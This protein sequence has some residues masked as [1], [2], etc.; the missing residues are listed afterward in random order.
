[1]VNTD[2]ELKCPKCGS[3]FISTYGNTVVWYADCME[4][5]LRG[6]ERPGMDWA[7]ATFCE[8][9]FLKEDDEKCKTKN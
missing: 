4:C 5:N 8:G 1:M 7:I 2:I 9:L 6:P 3:K